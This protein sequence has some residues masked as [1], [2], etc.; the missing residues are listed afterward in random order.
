MEF[1][2]LQ[3]NGCYGV[4]FNSDALNA[5]Q[6]HSACLRLQADSV[7]GILATIITDDVER[8]AARL[9][10]LARLREQ[11]PLAAKVIL[12]VHIEG[13]FINE[14]PGYVGAHPAEH[15]RAADPDIMK[16][17]LDAAAGLVSLVTLAPERDPGM[18]TT[19]F[20]AERGVLVSAGHSDASLDQLHAAIDAGL[21]MF[22]HLGNGCPTLLPRH[23][24]IIQRVLSL[25]DRLSICFIADGV[26]VPYT[27]LGNYLRIAGI[28]RTVFVTDCIAAAGLGRGRYALGN[29]PVV[30]DEEGATWSADRSHLMGSAI[31][32][33]CMA[34]KAQRELRLAPEDIERLVCGN[35]RRV[36]A[37][38]GSM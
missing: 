30:V 16:R 24:N 29:Q 12:G 9:V 32:M 26:H 14:Q 8:M 4:D 15:V 19:R 34:A 33:P 31:T 22:T 5:E 7:A 10:R 35:A 6:L 3:V 13:P 17:L 38:F 37:G 25:A 21:T 36:L 20:L 2:D 11:N 1:I 27:A 23:D 28:D 18:K